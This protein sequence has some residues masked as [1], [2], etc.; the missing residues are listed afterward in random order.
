MADFAYTTVPGKLSGLLE[1]IR[2]VGVPPK[3]ST[4]WLKSLGFTS[5]NDASLLGVLKQIGLIDP[6]SVPTSSWQQ[7]RGAH[8][9]KT[10][11][12]AIRSGYADLF[13]V[14]PDAWQRTQTE[15]EHVFST[16]TT[17]G[18]QVVAKTVTTF[19]NLC[20]SAEF[21]PVA[22]QTNLSVHTDPLHTAVT[23]KPGNVH[24]NGI[25]GIPAVHIDIQ[26]HISADSSPEQIDQ[27]FKSMG[28]HLYGVGSDA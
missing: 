28:K 6:S 12:D 3:A 21:S 8:H 15:L 14:Y 16:S 26:V 4:Q 5:S 1:K 20:A 10:L 11:G 18:K 17:A 9:K 22:E 27:I 7:Y 24:S 25:H 13:A 23:S 19:K 2:Q